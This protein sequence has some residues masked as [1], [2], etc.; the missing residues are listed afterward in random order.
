MISKKLTLCLGLIAINAATLLFAPPP[1]PSHA[2]YG[3]HAPDF[4]I[5]HATGK[6]R[7]LSD[8]KGKKIALC[9]HS[10]YNNA[11]CTEE[12]SSIY[13]NVQSLEKKNIVI[14]SISPGSGKKLARYKQQQSLPYLLISDP[15]KTIARAYK[16]SCTR[17]PW[18]WF[19][20]RQIFLIN[21]E[22]IIIG[23]YDGYYNIGA[24][25]I[26]YSAITDFALKI[27]HPFD[28]YNKYNSNLP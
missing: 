1:D 6:Q 25:E 3:K 9:F 8:F 22:G 28:V 13:N 21:E 15:G 24:V 4:I 18:N 7:K 27:I 26:S 19:S 20:H 14:I 16:S 2:L 10:K 17:F 11:L 5:P 23:I 12:L